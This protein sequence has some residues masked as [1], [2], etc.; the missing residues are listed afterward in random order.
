MELTFLTNILSACNLSLAD[1]ALVN[2]HNK[3]TASFVSE[4]K[5]KKVILFGISPLQFDLPFNFPHFQI[6][7][8][9]KTDYLTAPALAAISNDVNS[10]KE[11]W[12]S[13]KKM[14]NI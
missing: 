6:Q 14:F 10:K 3:E 13:L 12:T 4:L 5:S 2:W 9:D 1:V 11:L 7:N 8:F